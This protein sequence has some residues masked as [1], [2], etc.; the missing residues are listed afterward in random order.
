[1]DSSEIPADLAVIS[2]ATKPA[3]VRKKR[4]VSKKI[5]RL[6]IGRGRRKFTSLKVSF[7]RIGQKK[8]RSKKKRQVKKKKAKKK[9]SVKRKKR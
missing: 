8:R 5:K 2:N 1:M 6:Q 4:K 3:K 7:D 9:R